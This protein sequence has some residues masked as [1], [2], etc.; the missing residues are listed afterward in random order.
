MR[1]LRPISII[2][3]LAIL[4]MNTGDCV[5]LFFADAKEAEC[6]MK[7][8]CPF[9]AGQQMDSCCTKPVAPAKYIQAS[10]QRS[11]SQP[12]VT[13]IDFPTE[14]FAGPIVQ[15][16]A[17]HFSTDAKLHSPPGGLLLSLPLLI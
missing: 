10:T 3:G 11:L 7:A 8:D 15:T 1:L 2:L 14:A 6:C 17:V 12:S 9:A 16:T 4:L 5:N 13:A